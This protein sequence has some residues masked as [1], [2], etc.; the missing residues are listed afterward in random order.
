LIL[1]ALTAQIIEKILPV[2]IDVFN[3]ADTKA[4]LMMDHFPTFIVN[5]LAI[6]PV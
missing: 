4:L 6:Y 5:A 1:P 3:R 2:I